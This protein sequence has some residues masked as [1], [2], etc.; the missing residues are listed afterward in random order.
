MAL[1]RYPIIIL[2][3]QLD[4]RKTITTVLIQFHFVLIEVDKQKQI[5]SL[6][7]DLEI[8]YFSAQNVHLSDDFLLTK[9][10]FY[11]NHIFLLKSQD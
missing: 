2:F 8:D 11:D 5:M 6:T 9:S 7:G 1:F 3:N 4:H 10:H